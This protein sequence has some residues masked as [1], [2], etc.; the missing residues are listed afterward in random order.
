MTMEFP[1]VRMNR[2]RILARP[3]KRQTHWV[4]DQSRALRLYSYRLPSNN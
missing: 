2:R 4:R 3:P 1:S